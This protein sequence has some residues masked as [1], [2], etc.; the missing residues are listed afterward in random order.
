MARVVARLG[1]LVGRGVTIDVVPFGPV[2]EAATPAQ[3]VDGVEE[4]V[5][6]EA[7]VQRPS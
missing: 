6:A 4:R 7:E 1:H 5:V 3:L 2:V